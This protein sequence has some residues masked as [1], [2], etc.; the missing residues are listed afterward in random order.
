[1]CAGGHLWIQDAIAERC[2]RVL[3]H[4]GRYAAAI[5]V[6]KTLAKQQKRR[7]YVWGVPRGKAERANHRR[8]GLLSEQQA[9]M[10]ACGSSCS[11]L[12]QATQRRERDNVVGVFKQR[13]RPAG[14]GQDCH[15]IEAEIAHYRNRG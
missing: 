4:E 11:Y 12:D 2:H 15:R 5:M 8:S 9:E 14:L 6:S 13:R 7:T 3:L 10:G 1:V